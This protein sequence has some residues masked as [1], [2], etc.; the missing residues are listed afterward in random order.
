MK[1]IKAMSGRLNQHLV[2]AIAD[3]AIFLE[4]TG[5][6]LL[7][8]D[9]SIEAMEQL[10]MELQLMDK[11]DRDDL[12]RQLKDIGLRHEDQRKATFLQALP[13]AFGLN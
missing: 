7:D 5:E 8:Q 3:I 4:F 12:S 13:E 10:A 11:Q 1:G 6:E 2:Q 9:A